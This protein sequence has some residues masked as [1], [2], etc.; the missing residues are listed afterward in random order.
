MNK[1]K[2]E[3]TGYDKWCVLTRNRESK[4]KVW[5]KW[6]LRCLAYYYNQ[7]SFK[8]LRSDAAKQ[9]ES[10]MSNFKESTTS[11]SAELR[12]LMYSLGRKWETVKTNSLNLI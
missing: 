7:E 11:I 1:Y 8:F 2:N 3:E 9:Q 10:T 5:G 4:A 6:N 12:D